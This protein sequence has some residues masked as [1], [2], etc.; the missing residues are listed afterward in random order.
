MLVVLPA[1]EMLGRVKD[2]LLLLSLAAKERTFD[3]GLRGGVTFPAFG[4]DFFTF[5]MGESFCPPLS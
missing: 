3:I 2:F 4:G 5:I 1:A